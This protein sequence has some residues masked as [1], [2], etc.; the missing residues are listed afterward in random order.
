M[1]LSKVVFL[2][3]TFLFFLSNLFSQS[4]QQNI[5]FELNGYQNAESVVVVGTFNDWCKSK[6]SLTYNESENKWKVVKSLPFGRYEYRFVINGA[7]YLRDPSNPY[8]GG[9]YSNSLL[10]VNPP[11]RP[12]FNILTP[13]PGQVITQFP[14]EISLKVIPGSETEKID[15]NKTKIL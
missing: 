10:F 11:T 7:T 12:S 8:Y 5:S 1:R 14:M 4:T 2:N 15:K 3:F 13:K 6:D 9:E